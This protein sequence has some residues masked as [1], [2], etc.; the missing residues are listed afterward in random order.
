MV[1][2]IVSQKVQQFCT[3]SSD[4]WT[5]HLTSFLGAVF[6]AKSRVASRAKLTISAHCLKICSSSEYFLCLEHFRVVSKAVSNT[7]TF[8]M[9]L[10]PSYG[11]QVKFDFFPISGTQ[12]QLPVLAKPKMEILK[13]TY[14]LK[15]I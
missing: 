1:Y 7:C 9:L 2:V 8:H 4:L 10:H 15:V 13:P 14:P 6:P 5:A 11:F 3:F 12:T